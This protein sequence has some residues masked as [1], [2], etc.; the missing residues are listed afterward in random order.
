MVKQIFHYRIHFLL[1]IKGK[2]EKIGQ[3]N[4]YI[5]TQTDYQTQLLDGLFLHFNRH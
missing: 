2:D 3:N 4:P 5:Y 1:E